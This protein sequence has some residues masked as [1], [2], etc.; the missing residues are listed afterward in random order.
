MIAK[1]KRRRYLIHPSSQFKYI[2][3]SVLP[4]LVMSIFCIYFLVK[5]GE[6][7]LQKEKGKLSLQVSSIDETIQ[8]LER[9][10]YPKEAIEKI[11]VLKKKLL[12]FKE[13]LGIKHFAM[14]EEW[15]KTKM[16]LLAVLTLVLIC[17]GIMA[18]LYSHRIAG[19]LFRI[20]KSIDTLSEGKD[21]TPVQIRKYDEF[22]ELAGSLEKLRKTLKEK[23]F[24]GSR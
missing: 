6:L 24:L 7:L 11:E 16:S 12:I 17:V 15:A 19:P 8:Q 3:M 2:A 20:K 5:T 1:I 21:I 13:T 9:E 4:A 18:L 10:R 22:K 14:L 23:G